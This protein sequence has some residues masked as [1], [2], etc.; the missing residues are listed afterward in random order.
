MK[1]VNLVLSSFGSYAGRTEID[2]SRVDH[3]LFLITGDTGSGK[4]TL[5]DAITF[6][7]Y[8]TASGGSRDGKMMRSQYAS[9]TD[10]TY[11][12][13]TFRYRGSIYTVRRNPE[14]ERAKKNRKGEEGLTKELPSA[15]LTLPDGTVYRGRLRETDR[16]IQ[17]IIGLDREQFTQIMMIAQG[18]FLKLLLASSD[19]RKKI[20][21]GIFHTYGCR[22]VEEELGRRYSLLKEELGASRQRSSVLMKTLCSGG[23]ETGEKLALAAGQEAPDLEEAAALIDSLMEEDRECL[24]ETEINLRN[25]DQVIQKLTEK[26]ARQEA[27]NAGLRELEESREKLDKLKSQV[28]RQRVL[29][30]ALLLAERA[31]LIS[32]HE[33]AVSRLEREQQEQRERISGIKEEIAGEK[34]ECRERKLK[35]SASREE[36][37]WERLRRR[38]GLYREAGRF[39]EE[40]LALRSEAEESFRTFQDAFFLEQ[41]GILAEK[42]LEPGRP[43]PVCGSVTH[44]KPA[45]L[46]DGA[47]TEEDVKAAR[48]KSARA[49]AVCEKAAAEAAAARSSYQEEFLR[50]FQMSGGKDSKAARRKLEERLKQERATETEED[51]KPVRDGLDWKIWAESRE[52]EL[53]T[54][55]KELERHM[56][57]FS[58][59]RVLE[60]EIFRQAAQT[61]ERLK[62]AKETFRKVL[63]DQ[64]FRGRADYLRARMTPD[65]YASGKQSRESYEKE[66]RFLEVRI[67]TL[68]AHTKGV[69]LTDCGLWKSGK[70]EAERSRR[71]LMGVREELKGRIRQNGQIRRRIEEEVRLQAQL[72]EK[73]SMA[74]RLYRTAAGKLKGKSSV[75]YET[76]VQRRYFEQIIAAA[77]KRL[78]DMTGN[79]FKLQCRSIEASSLRGSAGLD[80]NV[81]TLATGKERDVKTLSGGESFLAALSMALGL[82]DVIQSSYGAQAFDTMFIDEGFGSLDES[83]RERVMQVLDSLA[84]GD[85]LIGVISHVAELKENIECH[86]E[87]KKTARGSTI[88]WKF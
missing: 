9:P 27:M 20:F 56:D 4:T 42:R 79:S 63:K 60:S 55:E 66:L 81:Y 44:P 59:A 49:S 2:F 14:Y 82:S 70:E 83:T 21:S 68:R 76:F 69:I 47:V 24:K 33:M 12:E 72:E 52:R 73:V 75:D 87:V 71:T 43:C 40:S 36:Y 57:R 30:R 26:I 22:A 5:F 38:E 48:D 61:G 45:R 46:P 23:G 78:L 50:Y 85:R 1:P 10:E 3:G 77:N 37:A 29:A 35:L 15:E 31:E 86:L 64:K 13:Y 54:M 74:G 41:A 16:K 6:A 84:G 62:E 58:S 8:G 11:V 34:K 32:V 80:L 67:E 28:G 7:L 18:E 39:L 65:E 51:G 19:E 25:Q 88:E 17:E 53:L